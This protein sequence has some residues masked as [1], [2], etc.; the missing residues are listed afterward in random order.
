MED[1]RIIF[2]NSKAIKIT[3]EMRQGIDAFTQK[4]NQLNS[5]MEELSELEKTYAEKQTELD[6]LNVQ[7]SSEDKKVVKEANKKI[8]ALEKEMNKINNSIKELN[9]KIE[10]ESP[11]NI[12]G[13]LLKSISDI[14]NNEVAPVVEMPSIDVELE[15]NE[16]APIEENDIFNQTPVIEEPQD[17]ETEN[18]EESSN[19]LKQEESETEKVDEIAE[20][21]PINNSYNFLSQ[22]DL[23]K[24]WGEL[25]ET[26]KEKT[27]NA[28]NKPEETQEIVEEVENKE[29]EKEIKKPMIFGEDSK[30]NQIASKKVAE[31]PLLNEESTND[32]IPYV[33]Y[34]DY[35]FKFGQN[36]Y[37]KEALT[38][39]E[40]TEL[41]NV[42]SFLNEDNFTI[43]RSGQYN[44]VV[45]ENN[46]LREKIVYIDTEYKKQID[47]LSA[48]HKSNLDELSKLID[49]A[50]DKIDDNKAE[51]ASLNTK[52]NELQDTI[53]N[54]NDK[55]AELEQIKKEHEDK[56]NDYENKFK[57]VFNIVKEIKNSEK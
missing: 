26:V 20:E 35:V 55:I 31:E 10:Q 32:L 37:G 2:E 40:I 16:S 1:K 39:T 11:N 54:L 57:D 18:Q 33:D 13:V 9:S 47:D 36:H 23:D 43:K 17:V 6:E 44:N 25:N 51:I 5:S 56:I 15:P 45:K 49:L 21:F 34:N 38:P 46:D 53:A 29:D 30:F 41:S 4:R 52:N 3:E 42:E 7:A 19:E 12:N 22:D 14:N 48:E 24:M 50:N 8:K 28:N 27:D